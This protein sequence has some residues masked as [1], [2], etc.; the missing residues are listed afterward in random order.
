[1]RPYIII[2]AAISADGKLST[3][4]RCQVPISGSEDFARVDRM[5]AD[6]DAILVGIGTVL[7][8]DPSLTV[9]SPALREERKNR[10]ADENPVRIV[11]D[12]D[13][14]TPTTADILRKGEGKRIIAVSEKADPERM[15]ALGEYA[16]VITSGEDT[17]DLCS[18]VQELGNRKIKTLMVEG[19]GTV[20]WSFLS[21]GLFD[22]LHVYLGSMIIGGK[23]APTLADGEGFVD[24]SLFPRLTLD[25]VGQMDD[26]VLIRWKRRE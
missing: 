19:G 23:T 6:C 22:E 13:A 26:G 21:Q 17:V 16:E 3:R 2:N 4:E 14:Q 20:I 7:A 1:M 24:Q 12:S 10:K 9:K 18:F 5:R 8:D 11:L 15:E 25:H